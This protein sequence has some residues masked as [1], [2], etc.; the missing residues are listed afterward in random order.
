[1]Q[2]GAYLSL[3]YCVHRPTDCILPARWE[4]QFLVGGEGVINMQFEVKK[5]WRPIQKGH[6]GIVEKAQ[7]TSLDSAMHNTVC[8]CPCRTS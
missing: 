5:E 8:L 1:M 7:E 4:I 3:V 6:I 2:K